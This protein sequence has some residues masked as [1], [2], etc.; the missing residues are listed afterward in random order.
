MTD[1]LQ[2]PRTVSKDKDF[3][4]L[5]QGL[6]HTRGSIVAVFADFC[7]TSACALAVGGREPEYMEAIK[8]YSRDDLQV[9][10]RALSY[11]IM[12]MEAAPFVDVLGPYYTE[13]SSAHTRD[14]RGEFFT[15]PP[16]AD[17]LAQLSFDA[18]TV[19]EIGRP[20]TVCDPAGGSGGLILACA[21][22]LKPDVD[23]MRATLQDINPTAC[24]MAYI[25]TTLWG[26]PA[27]I[28]LGNTLKGEVVHRWTNI[29]WHRVGEDLRRAFAQLAAVP[30]GDRS[31]AKPPAR[32][33]SSP[34]ETDCDHEPPAQPEF[35]W[36]L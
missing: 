7:R 22:A 32:P 31:A 11:L 19:R 29:H 8:P 20:V 12:E 28:L 21:R 15:P 16:I 2:F 18:E 25:N 26:I 10:A 14:T 4:E 27:E 35:D 1:N 34:E 9:F 24:N 17:L 33:P 6:A 30:P 23:L 3:R 5:L 36:N 13:I